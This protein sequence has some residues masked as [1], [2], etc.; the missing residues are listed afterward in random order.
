M[1]Q[2]VDSEAEESEVILNTLT[3]IVAD[4]TDYII[5]YITDIL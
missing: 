3:Y 4:I 2:F 5:D 1:S